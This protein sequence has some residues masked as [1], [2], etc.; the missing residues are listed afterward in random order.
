MPVTWLMAFSVAKKNRSVS[1]ASD[2]ERY[3]TIV[4]DSVGVVGPSEVRL[5]LH[6]LSPVAIQAL[7]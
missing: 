5:I 7:S 2:R 1:I 6:V 4:S 3:A